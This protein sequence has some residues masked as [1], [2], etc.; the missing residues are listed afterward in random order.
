MMLIAIS[1]N[2]GKFYA[3][4]RFTN[5]LRAVGMITKSNP[6]ECFCALGVWRCL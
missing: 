2:Q 5:R 3:A 6:C 4:I 1:A